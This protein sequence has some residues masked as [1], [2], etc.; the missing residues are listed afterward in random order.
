[1]TI[2]VYYFTFPVIPDGKFTSTITI[3]AEPCL[4]ICNDFYHFVLFTVPRTFR[5]T[6]KIAA[7]WSL[8]VRIPEAWQDL[9]PSIQNVALKV[10]VGQD[11]SCIIHRDSITVNDWKQTFFGGRFTKQTDKKEHGTP[12]ASEQGGSPAEHAELNVNCCDDCTSQCCHMSLPVART[13]YSRDSLS[14]FQVSRWRLNRG[15][16]ID[17]EEKQDRN[18]INIHKP[19]RELGDKNRLCL[20]IS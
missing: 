18:V 13:N 17:N 8:L 15:E 11:H 12:S 4:H 7:D 16:H 9:N 2:R 10:R 14:Y 5:R 20:T 6:P 1:V 3:G 19:R